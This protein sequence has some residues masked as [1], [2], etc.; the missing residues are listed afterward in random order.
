MRESFL[1]ACR[2]DS[3]GQSP[4]RPIRR[5]AVAAALALETVGIVGL[6]MWPLTIATL[7][8]ERP[9]VEQFPIPIGHVLANRPHTVARSETASRSTLFSRRG[10][11]HIFFAGL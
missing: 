6:A 10:F 3:I 11:Q 2:V 4:G 9:H 7:P 5:R 8:A 1:K